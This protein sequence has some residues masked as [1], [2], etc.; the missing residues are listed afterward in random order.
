MDTTTL[1]SNMTAF[2]LSSC[3]IHHGGETI[4]HYEKFADASSMLVP[5]N[6]CTKSVMSSLY[7]IAMGQ[8]ILPE[9]D[10]FI[11]EFFP[12]LKLDS[13]DRKQRIT[14]E[15]LL[16]LTAGFKW[17]EFG[18]LN[19]FPAMTRTS[20]WMDYVLN[21]PMSDE[22]GTKM[23]YNSGVSQ[24][25]A[26]IF[27]QATGFSLAQ[28]AERHLFEP[29]GILHYEWKVDPQGVH[30]GGYGLELSAYD[31]LSFGLLYLHQ[32]LW[33]K[34]QLIIPAILEHSIQPYIAATPPERG[35]YAWHWWSDS[36]E[37]PSNDSKPTLLQFF[38]ARGFGGQ[39]I[40][41]VPTLDAVIVLTRKQRKKGV[42]PLELFRQILAPM[43]V[44]YQSN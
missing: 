31:M 16:T 40:I 30:T 24:M 25:L 22:P 9:K 5:V 28:F 37:I 27:V 8:G 10:V 13:D 39:F 33:N 42:S 34:Q 4:F 35:Y 2:D 32:G 38:Y 7:C 44:S 11:T 20:H 41:V 18:G 3:I 36:V 26:T 21:Q 19:S 29:L 23:N 17:N 6:S 1:Y 12:Q 15:H 14:L 43:L